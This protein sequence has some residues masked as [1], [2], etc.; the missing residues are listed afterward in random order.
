MAGTRCINGRELRQ[1]YEHKG[2]E[3][4]FNHLSEALEKK[5]LRP[6]DFSIA[7]LFEAIVGPDGMQLLRPK[8][9]YSSHARLMESDAVR[10][11]DFS[12]ITGQILFTEM[13]ENLMQEEFVF[14]KIVPVKPSKI[15]GIEKIPGITNIGDDIEVVG[16]NQTYPSLGVSQDYIEIA[17]KQ[18]R[19]GIVNVTKEAILGDLTGM[20]LD[21]CRTLGKIVGL[22]REKRIIDAVVDENAGATSIHNGGHRYNW[23]GTNIGATYANN[24][25]NHNWDNLQASNGLVDWSDINAAWLLLRN[26]TDPFTAEPIMVQPRHLVVTPQNEWQARMIV[27]A[28]AVHRHAGGYATSGN[29]NETVS[30]NPVPQLEIV[31]SA[32]LAA[33]LAT[34]T[35][36]YLGE[37]SKAF[38]VYENW[39][40]TT[41]ESPRD[42]Y[43]A[44]TRDVTFSV[45]CSVK[46]C[47]ATIEPRLMVESQA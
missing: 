28:T 26:M 44:W 32:L 16:E 37:L 15:Q 4:V 30:G 39:E 5:H 33:R 35:D 7:E 40:P 47:V 6:Q 14:S 13:K 19:G 36:W 11:S 43:D 45:K 24:S 2:G 10:F 9:G 8:S 29:L 17:A 21:Q 12:Q 38:A 25:G 34:D 27:S 20:L 3:Q 41:E 18:K 31:S 42:S 46:D 22:S 23:R 1:L